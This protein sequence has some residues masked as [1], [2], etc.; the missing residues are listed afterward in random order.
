M[1]RILSMLEDEDRLVRESACLALGLM[2]AGVKAEEAVAEKWFVIN[3]TI[4]C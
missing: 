2:K 4:L 3:C 1:D